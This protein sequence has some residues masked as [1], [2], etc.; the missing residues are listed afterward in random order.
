MARN[1]R[2]LVPVGGFKSD[3][4]RSRATMLAKVATDPEKYKRDAEEKLQQLYI[5]ASKGGRA[6]Q[7][8]YHKY[9]T[10]FKRNGYSFMSSNNFVEGK[11]E[12]QKAKKLISSASESTIT[13]RQFNDILD[14]IRAS[15][16]KREQAIIRRNVGFIE[17]TKTPLRPQS[18]AKAAMR[19]PVINNTGTIVMGGFTDFVLYIREEKTFRISAT[20]NMSLRDL[21]SNVAFHSDADF[22]L[23][24]KG[25]PLPRRGDLSIQDYGITNH[26]T[27]DR[28]SSLL[29]GRT[30]R[31]RCRGTVVTI[32]L[33]E[34]TFDAVAPAGTKSCH[35]PTNIAEPICRAFGIGYFVAW[36]LFGE[37]LITEELCRDCPTQTFNVVFHFKPPMIHHSNERLPACA[38]ANDL[39]DALYFKSPSDTAI[40]YHKNGVMPYKYVP[41]SQ[42]LLQEYGPGTFHFWRHVDEVT[43]E[44]GLRGGAKTPKNKHEKGTEPPPKKKGKKCK[45][46]KTKFCTNCGK[47]HKLPYCKSDLENPGNQHCKIC[48]KK[49]K[50][51]DN[52]KFCRIDLNEDM[53]GTMPTEIKMEDLGKIKGPSK[54]VLPNL[55]VIVQVDDVPDQPHVP[56]PPARTFSSDVKGHVKDFGFKLKTD[57]SIFVGSIHDL[58][59]HIK[60]DHYYNR[61]FYFDIF[62]IFLWI[63]YFSVSIFDLYYMFSL[64]PIGF[65]E[66]R[67]YLFCFTWVVHVMSFLIGSIWADYDFRLYFRLRLFPKYIADK[68]KVNNRIPKKMFL[69]DKILTIVST[70]GPLDENRIYHIT[71]KPWVAA[72]FKETASIGMYVQN[73][74]HLGP[75]EWIRYQFF[76]TALGWWLPGSADH[77]LT[78]VLFSAPAPQTHKNIQMGTAFK[79]ENVFYKP[80]FFIDHD[81]FDMRSI[82]TSLGKLIHKD[83]ALLCINKIIGRD[84][85][86]MTSQMVI[87]TALAIEALSTPA[88]LA[89]S[90]QIDTID[91]KIDFF[92]KNCHGVNLTLMDNLTSN[93]FLSTKMYVHDAV[94][95]R[96]QHY[97]ATARAGNVLSPAVV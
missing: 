51:H 41:R 47:E 9:L 17:S 54:E 46:S 72:H 11:T 94:R 26:S 33:P 50:D 56:P 32:P 1:L 61:I 23:S 4:Q 34:E 85:N 53:A 48:R 83:P 70:N 12:Q 67:I 88:L 77:C 93:V 20:Y 49:L 10:D 87:S 24:Y 52:G 60:A 43:E 45:G 3:Q 5:K 40:I 62:I 28:A 16:Y 86:L 22:M 97:A 25:K 96:R 35:L 69:G 64:D 63:S 59:D 75:M 31:V 7:T 44:E 39:Y 42:T 76:R 84:E 65:L 81:D 38:C 8:R 66:H 79:K 80:A 78:G 55:E 15:N 95:H 71:T 57:R 82:A 19:E 2:T 21:Y 6:A 37:I 90:E 74:A 36:N 30:I 68:F 27:I 92:F 91:S 18:W 29:G 14:L 58:V 89:T 73:M 13:A